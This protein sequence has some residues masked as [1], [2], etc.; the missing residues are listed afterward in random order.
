MLVNFE[1]CP[2]IDATNIGEICVDIHEMVIKWKTSLFLW[3]FWYLQGSSFSGVAL[4]FDVRSEGWR[5]I[6]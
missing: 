2:N 3:A 5:F 1:K 4:A 6:E